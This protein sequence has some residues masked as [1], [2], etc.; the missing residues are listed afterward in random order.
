M[1]GIAPLLKGDRVRPTHKPRYR[2]VE[3][4]HFVN[5]GPVGRPKDRDWRAGYVL[6]GIA[7]GS[8]KVEFVRVPSDLVTH[9]PEPTSAPRDALIWGTGI[10]SRVRVQ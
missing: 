9:T 8:V 5:T 7:E 1:A 10:Y 4:I 3:A 2:E 6:L